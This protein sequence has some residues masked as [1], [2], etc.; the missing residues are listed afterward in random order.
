MLGQLDEADQEQV[1]LRLLSDPAFCEEFDVVVDEISIRYA[2]GGF[3]GD[4]KD[5]VE[6]YFLRAPERQNKVRVMSELLHYSAAT[7]GQQPEVSPVSTAVERDSSWF[8]RIRRFWSSQ[9]LTFRFATTVAVLVIVAG[10]I[11]LERSR[12][13]TAPN[14]M[15]L[16]LTSTDAERGQQDGANAVKSVKLERGIDEL[17]I[18]LLL[19]PPQAQP[20]S[21][22]A[23]MIPADTSRKLTVVF[24][25]SQSVVVSVP[26][27]QLTPDRY[28]IRLFAVSV[29][30]REERVGGNYLFRVE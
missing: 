3:E 10:M 4:Q 24:H 13:P 30:G 28:A 20:Q 5:R 18:Q 17:R 12:R 29:D 16:V 22:R 11:F 23:E 9:P 25:D 15:A 21:Y 19:P 7:R 1:E 8:A 26:T 27:F 2:A 14:Y 6:R